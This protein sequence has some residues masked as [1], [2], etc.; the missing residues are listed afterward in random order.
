MPTYPRK[1]I[2]KKVAIFQKCAMLFFVM[3]LH[4]KYFVEDNRAAVKFG[5][6]P[7][8]WFEASHAGLEAAIT[9]ARDAKS[10][11][12]CKVAPCD[13]SNSPYDWE[14]VW[15]NPEFPVCM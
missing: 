13:L 9:F 14:L 3:R 8:R 15:E 5:R 4:D 12:K 1:K 11:V 6:R 2:K 10:S 7:V